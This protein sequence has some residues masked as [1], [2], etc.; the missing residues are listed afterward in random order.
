VDGGGLSSVS[1][2]RGMTIVE[3]MVAMVA[4]LAMLFAILA[5]VQVATH[6]QRRVASHVAANQR[7]RPV[8][9]NIMDALHSGCVARGVAPVLAAS[10][11]S[12]MSFLSQSGS[13]VSPTPDKHVV[14]L[15]G[16]TLSESVYPATGGASP[17]WTFSPTPSSTRQLLTGVGS[18]SAG[19]PPASVPL[20]RYYAYSGGQVSATPLATPLSADDAA[21]TVQVT[22]A[23]SSSA[24]GGTAS[25][26]E[27]P[28]SLSDSAI[29]RL[30]PASEDSSEVNL[31]CV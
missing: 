30:E 14:T 15:S 1:D 13:A 3:V 25:D 8:L 7:G 18:G 11:A 23:F 26:T 27:E 31:P 22:V 2:Q 24:N 5:L 20:F 6:G 28:I 4:S 10:G 29:L 16:T 17:N 12:S 9:T 21:K 19:T